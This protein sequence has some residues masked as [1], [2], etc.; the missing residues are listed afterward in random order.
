MTLA[1]AVHDPGFSDRILA[2]CREFAHE[3]L[4]SLQPA[5]KPRLRR[6]DQEGDDQYEAGRSLFKE[7]R[8]TWQTVGVESW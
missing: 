7:S 4:E 6:P 8:Q 2:A 3:N 1:R 5:K